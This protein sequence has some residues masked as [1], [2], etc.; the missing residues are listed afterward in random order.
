M[1][2][3]KAKRQDFSASWQ[4]IRQAGQGFAAAHDKI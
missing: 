4:T 2:F 3:S 1:A